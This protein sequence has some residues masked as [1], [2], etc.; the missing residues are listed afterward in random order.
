MF[1][2][3]KQQSTSKSFF[4]HS[5]LVPVLA[6]GL[7]SF[8]A[9]AND[10]DPRLAIELNEEHK[11]QLLSNMRG[12]LA[13]TQSI[14]NALAAD[15]MQAVADY[16]RPLGFKARQQKASDGL[17]NALP[18]SF[19]IMGRAMHQ[20]FDKIADDAETLKD[21]KHSLQQLAAV[22]SSCQGCHETFRIEAI[23]SIES[24]DSETIEV[25]KSFFQTLFMM[26]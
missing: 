20:D 10:F 22:M 13:A 3:S 5:I 16:A 18:K 15:D 2:L 19:K 6:L 26:E 25:E 17:H 4:K 21:P 12:A 7:V 9:L 8:N 1:H 14:V 11:A 23:N 24:A